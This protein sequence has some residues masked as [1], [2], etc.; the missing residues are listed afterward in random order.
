MQPIRP[1]WTAERP[2][3]VVLPMPRTF[4]ATGAAGGGGKAIAR[5]GVMYPPRVADSR[6]FGFV[7]CYEWTTP[8]QR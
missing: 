8:A 2:T 5:T 7:Q 3:A 1:A 6:Q 4:V